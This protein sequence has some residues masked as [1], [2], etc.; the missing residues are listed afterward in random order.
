MNRLLIFFLLTSSIL[1]SKAQISKNELN[2]Y[3]LSFYPIDLPEMFINTPMNGQIEAIEIVKNDTM[4]YKTFF[5]N[6]KLSSVAIDNT[7][8]TFSY[9]FGRLSSISYMN[10]DTLAGR[11]KIFK[12]LPFVLVFNHGLTHTGFQVFG[13]TY[14]IRQVSGWKTISK[15]KAIYKRGRVYQIKNYGWQT[16][17]QRCHFIDYYLFDYP[18][19]TTVIERIYDSNDSLAIKTKYVFDNSGNM[20][21]TNSLIRKR[22]SGWGID[23]TY[24][25]YDANKTERFTFKYKLD[26]QNNWIEKYGYKNDTLQNR[27]LRQINYKK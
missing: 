7:K 9:L 1:P 3:F 15:R 14:S 12:L 25:S 22:A 21:E 11:T 6:Y 18:N 8:M 5:K 23:V 4:T 16:V 13:K 19:D 17:A 27:E 24:Y 10:H 20:K 26:G 2:K